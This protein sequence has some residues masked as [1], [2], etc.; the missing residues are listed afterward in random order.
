MFCSVL[1]GGLH[2]CGIGG[3][4][5]KENVE[6]VPYSKPPRTP[7]AKKVCAISVSCGHP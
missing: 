4:G 2:A 3:E 1:Q 7:R 5:G 6:P